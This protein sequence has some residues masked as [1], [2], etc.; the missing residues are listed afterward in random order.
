M[1]NLDADT[2]ELG[3]FQSPTRR[4]IAHYWF[5]VSGLT[6]DDANPFTCGHDPKMLTL[7]CCARIQW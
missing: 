3:N 5:E 6:T 7:D 1:D 4:L 2:V